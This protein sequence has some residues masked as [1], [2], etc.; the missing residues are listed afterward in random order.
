MADDK[1]VKI[2]DISTIG[3]DDVLQDLERINQQFIDIKKNKL[4]LNSLKASIE[5]PEELKKVDKEL[6]N[7]L[8]KEK[9]LA[10][11]LKQK[12]IQMKEYQLIAAAEREAKKKEVAGNTALA[13]SYNEVNKKYK[14]L[15]AISKNSTNL[16][17]PQEVQQAQ[18]EL[19]KYKDLLDN[20]N[21]GLTKD[22]TLVGEYTTGILQ[23]FKNSG[24]DDVISD[25]LK[26]AKQNV[27]DLDKEFEQLKQELRNIQVTGQGSLQVVEQQLLENRRA[28]QG[29][30]DQIERVENELRTMNSMGSSIGSSIGLQFK[31][32]KK[33]IAGFVISYVSF[34]GAIAASQGVKNQTIQLDSLDASLKAVSGSTDEYVK[35][36]TFLKELADRLGVSLLTTSQA[37]K[38]FY[39]SSTL[40]GISQNET[41]RIFESATEAASVL[42][43]SQDDLNGVL[44]AF[45][46]IASKGKVQAEELRGQIGERLPGAFAIAAKSM[47][48]S[49]QAL[50]KMLKDGKV[51]SNEFLPKFATE[52]KKTF[53]LGGEEAVGLAATLARVQTRI[54]E[55][56]KSNQEGFTKMINGVSAFIVALL[57]LATYI[58]SLPLSV[59]VT[60]IT[61]VAVAYTYLSAQNA[62]A[63]KEGLLYQ[64]LIKGQIIWDGLA[65]TAKKALAFATSLATKEIVLFGGAI[66]VTPLGIFITVLGLALSAF[67]AFADESNRAVQS[68]NN[69]REK[70][71]LLN[72]AQ[73]LAQKSIQDTINKEKVYISIAKDRTLSDVARQKALDKLIELS[74]GYLKSLTLQNI[75]TEKGT[76]LIN[77]Y[78]T[79]LREQALTEA[80]LSIA[81]RE[82]DKIKTIQTQQFDL[83]RDYKLKGNLEISDLPKEVQDIVLKNQNNFL[84]RNFGQVSYANI[85]QINKFFNDAITKQ[86]QRA[87]EAIENTGKTL[88]D[89]FGPEQ[90]TNTPTADNS[91][92][93]K[94]KASSL[95]NSQKDYLKDLQAARD[96]ALAENEK[97]FTQGLILEEAYLT[98]VR[99]INV[100]FLNQKIGYLKG[101]N[102]EERKEIAES[103]RDKEKIIRDTNEKLYN[104]DLKQLERRKS[105]IDD[106]IKNEIQSV[107]GDRSLSESD[108]IERKIKLDQQLIQQQVDYMNQVDQLEKMFNINSTANSEQLAEALK[109]LQRELNL[110]LQEQQLIALNQLD[111]KQRESLERIK[112]SITARGI[113]ILGNGGLNENQRQ[114]KLKELERQGAKELEDERLSQIN[115]EFSAYA[116]MLDKKLLSQSEYNKKVS[117]LESERLDLIKSGMERE[118]QAEKEKNDEK[119]KVLQAGYKIA[120]EFIDTYLKKLAM[121]VEADY[122]AV[123]T[124]LDLEKERKLELAQSAAEKQAIEEEYKAKSDAA[125][126]ERNIERQE[127]ARKQLAVEFALASIKAISTATSIY[128]GI[129]KEAIVVAE[130][131]AALSLLNAQQ[132][133]HGGKVQ[134]YN[135][136]NGRIT[137]GSN[138]TPTANGDNILAYV[139]KNEV[140]LNEKQQAML[141]GDK[142][143]ASI[144]VPG[145]SNNSY[146]GASVQPPIF[147]SYYA[148][149]TASSNGNSNDI[150]EIKGIVLGLSKIIERESYKPVL[151]DT[152]NLKSHQD[153]QAKKVNLATV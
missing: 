95:T 27:S 51:I 143:F 114:K 146:Y 41:R 142:T 71:I 14:E 1:I 66:R 47:G 39:A 77:A 24:L 108:K 125:E 141:G 110:D 64:A 98:K 50:D 118:L 32:L 83:N 10:T 133:A 52:L 46:Q 115:N 40:A 152:N 82:F 22:G 16:L 102:A 92:K 11:E 35:N 145:F 37:F 137:E 132:F 3:S 19:K 20:F 104:L 147:R 26:K 33:D 86:E 21:R 49:Q 120:E 138:I 4:S 48:V 67:K 17:N 88:A 57:S 65:A 2:Y 100:K 93:P 13:G 23:A 30:Q 54:T 18:T 76:K 69:Y 29:F 79:K 134:P 31:N 7:L 5:D 61:A 148:S 151:L 38:S 117:E 130:Y 127:V 55:F 59:L 140:I 123:R 106:A 128:D 113:G 116:N 8:L 84:T 15:L 78:N 25:Q 12:Q 124:Q 80:K 53:S 111:A 34:Q 131:L 56:V 74:G 101:T 44:L 150:A 62:L 28:A 153:S 90:S 45:G 81:K 58:T 96:I 68:L 60:G 70:M 105:L 99:D 91:K 73:S 144:G 109:E 9:Q 107:Q 121:L 6:T 129:A 43:L 36:Q 112:R 126:R 149:S 63:T 89:I 97:S 119:E 122:N 85:E 103:Q 135:L 87:K 94:D 72:E 42:K 139:K 136:S 75:E